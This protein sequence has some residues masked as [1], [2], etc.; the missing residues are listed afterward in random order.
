MNA[1]TT[2]VEIMEQKYLV[3]KMLPVVGGYIWQKLMAAMFKA[4]QQAGSQVDEDQTAEAAEA[5][6]KPKSTPDARLRGLCG[7]AFMHLEYKDFAFIQ[8]SCMKTVSRFENDLPMPIM[9]DSG[10]WVPPADIAENLML[11]TRLTTEALVF[12]LASFL[13]ESVKSPAA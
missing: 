1:K 11:V 13:D 4:A 2:V 7:I 10:Q 6:A 8:E 12:N 9:S 5:T 3:R